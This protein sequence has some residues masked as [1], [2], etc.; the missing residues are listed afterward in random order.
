M[1]MYISCSR[2][3]HYLYLLLPHHYTPG[4]RTVLTKP[5]VITVKIELRV[6]ESDNAPTRYIMDAVVKHM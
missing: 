6:V 2:A 3:R 1:S 5:K 4:E